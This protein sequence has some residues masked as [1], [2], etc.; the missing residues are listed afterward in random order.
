MWTRTTAGFQRAISTRIR[1]WSGRFLAVQISRYSLET[2]E[3]FR[4]TAPRLARDLVEA[5]RRASGANGATRLTT[6]FVELHFNQLA[7][8]R[9]PLFNSVPTRLQS[10]FADC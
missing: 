6:Y 3:M 9:L 2:L 7:D 8:D 5:S 1:I 10:L 4:E